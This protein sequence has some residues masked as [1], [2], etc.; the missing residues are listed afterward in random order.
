MFANLPSHLIRERTVVALNGL[1]LVVAAECPLA[2]IIEDV[3]WIDERLGILDEPDKSD[4]N[5]QHSRQSELCT[6]QPV[7]RSQ[8]TRH[9]RR[10]GPWSSRRCAT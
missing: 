3:H 2:L 6:R 1:L 8:P 10:R 5:W 9:A 4:G 7:S